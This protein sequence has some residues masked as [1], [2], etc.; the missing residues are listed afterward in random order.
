V[1]EPT[2]KFGARAH[3]GVNKLGTA[4][5][6]LFRRRKMSDFTLVPEK[7]RNEGL[8]RGLVVATARQVVIGRCKRD[9]EVIDNMKRGGQ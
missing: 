2:R 5:I 7:V 8:K 1:I 4:T 9:Q 6:C 3:E